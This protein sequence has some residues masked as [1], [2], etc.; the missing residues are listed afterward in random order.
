MAWAASRRRERMPKNWRSIR[1]AV[2]RRDGGRCMVRV[3]GRV[4]G[5]PAT[6]VHHVVE[7]GRLGGADD[8][9]PGNLISICARHHRIFTKLY[10]DER[11]AANRAAARPMS[12]H[13]GVLDE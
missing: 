12:S 7:A 13:P 1:A 6:E 4:C 11:R 8:D 9:R 10:S 5:A 3:G 2:L